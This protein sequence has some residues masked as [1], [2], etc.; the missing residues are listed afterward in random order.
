[1]AISVA[2]F[3]G[4]AKLEGEIDREE[5]RFEID[6]GSKFEMVCKFDRMLVE[7]IGTFIICKERLLESL[8]L[9]R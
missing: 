6:F 7:L 9:R 1:M 3:K 4:K 2:E 8:I 5:S